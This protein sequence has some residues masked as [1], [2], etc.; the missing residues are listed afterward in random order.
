M[1]SEKLIA[2]VRTMLAEAVQTFTNGSLPDFYSELPP[3][4]APRFRK[5]RDELL[6]YLK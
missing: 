6:R 5:A 2:M 3:G 1:P 4:K